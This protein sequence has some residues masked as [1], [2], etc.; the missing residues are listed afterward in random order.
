MRTIGAD[1]IA[2][3]RASLVRP[4]V[5]CDIQFSDQ[6]VRFWSGV[7]PLVVGGNTYTGTGML[8]KISSITE[9]ADVQANGI[10][11]SLSGIP[12]NLVM[13]AIGECQQGQ[14]VIVSIGFMD[15]NWAVIDTPAI[16]F[17]GAMDTV[18]IDEGADTCTIIVTAESRMTDLRRPRIRR[19]T[20]DD[21][22]RTAPGDRGF[23]FVPMV[24]DWN[25]N[26]NHNRS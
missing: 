2:Q 15:T 19:Y 5:T 6:W 4:F 12:S 3:L 13:E 21:Q 9:T 14:T 11:L 26:W 22:Q 16:L 24:Q 17:R 7:G 10:K 1:V 25:G 23:E 18:S 8:G 20:D